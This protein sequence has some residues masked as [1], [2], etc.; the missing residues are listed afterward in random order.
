MDTKLHD[1]IAR[2]SDKYLSFRPRTEHEMH[3]Y[4]QRKL[5]RK[6][7]LE[8][9]KRTQL[10]D[11]YVERLKEEGRIDDEAFVRWYVAEKNYF[12]PRGRIRLRYDL[13]ALGIDKHILDRVLEENEIP[14]TDL[15]TQ[16][17]ETKYSRIPLDE[18]DAREKL[19]Q[20]LQRRGFSYSDI[21]SSIE[22]Y[23]KKE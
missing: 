19:T 18:E 8:P 13:G 4:L 10:I 1:Y 6:E 3:V 14:D 5:A 20:R 12:K 17:L 23:R 2:C 7:E 11:A 9:E 16:L 22:D 21:K 15:I